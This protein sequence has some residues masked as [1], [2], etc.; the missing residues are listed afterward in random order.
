MNSTT[1]DLETFSE[2]LRENV[3]FCKE[4][5]QYILLKDQIFVLNICEYYETLEK[6][7]DKQMFYLH[8]YWKIMKENIEDEKNDHF[9]KYGKRL[10]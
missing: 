1:S 3:S 7:S 8:K 4:N 5:I 6:L 2:N 10:Y 9:R